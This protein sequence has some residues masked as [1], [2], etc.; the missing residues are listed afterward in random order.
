M[1]LAR[2]LASSCRALASEVGD[3][4]DSGGKS[5]ICSEQGTGESQN[6][7]GSAGSPHALGC[8]KN[9]ALS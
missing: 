9:G 5:T 8:A 6:L 4:A 7:H 3:I 2:P 1:P